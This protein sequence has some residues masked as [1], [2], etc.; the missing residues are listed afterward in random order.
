[1]IARRPAE[2]GVTVITR[3]TRECAFTARDKI[4]AVLVGLPGRRWAIQ[5]VVALAGVLTP[6]WGGLS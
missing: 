4:F 3:L 6:A 1:M 5:V 2:S